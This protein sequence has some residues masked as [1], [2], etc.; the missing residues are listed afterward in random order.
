MEMDIDFE[1]SNNPFINIKSNSNDNPFY[2]ALSSNENNSTYEC[3]NSEITEIR[4]TPKFNYKPRKKPLISSNEVRLQK[5]IN[6]LKQV[7]GNENIK[8]N[9]YIKMQGT[10]NI[11][12]IIEFID[13]FSVEFL[14][15][16]NYPFDPPIISYYSGNKIPSIFDSDGK[17]ILE[18]TKE[19]KWTPT[20]WLSKIIKSIQTLISE[21]PRS[22]IPSR[23][24][25]SKRK[26]ED[27]LNEEKSFSYGDNIINELNKSIKIYK[28]FRIF[29]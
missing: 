19:Q 4:R 27:Y 29:N 2:T 22:F 11:K 24:K 8:I 23:I 12:M 13:Y 5:D 21:L 28:T 1:N 26:W 25:Y 10:D 6:H 3:T 9:D 16:C 7:G 17:I 15:T 14:F 18:E 20:T